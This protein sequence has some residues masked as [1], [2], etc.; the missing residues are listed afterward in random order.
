[1][2]DHGGWKTPLVVQLLSDE[3]DE[4]RW[5][6]D[7]GAGAQQYRIWEEEGRYQ[8]WRI[9]NE[10]EGGAILGDEW[11]DTLDAALRVIQQDVAGVT[12]G[13]P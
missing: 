9:I 2:T 4:R 12:K 5:Y 11:Q 7:G 3:H 1:M 8:C 6:V 13:T 10:N